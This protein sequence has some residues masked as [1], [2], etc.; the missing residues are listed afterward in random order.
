LRGHAGAC[1]GAKQPLTKEDW[2]DIANGREHPSIGEMIAADARRICICGH[3]YPTHAAGGQC[4]ACSECD[5]FVD[6]AD[7]REAIGE[8]QGA[9]ARY[10]K[11]YDATVLQCEA[12]RAS[13]DELAASLRRVTEERNQ[14]RADVEGIELA[15]RSELARSDV[16]EADGARWKTLAEYGDHLRRCA[17]YDVSEDHEHLCDCGFLAAYQGAPSGCHFTHSATPP[18]P[19]PSEREEDR[20]GADEAKSCSHTNTIETMP[21]V[22]RDCGKTLSSIG[23]PPLRGSA[24]PADASGAS[25][26]ERDDDLARIARHNGAPDEFAHEIAS[27]VASAVR[28]ECDRAEVPNDE[29][30][31]ATRAKLD[32]AER[33]RDDLRATIAAEIECIV[34]GRIPSHALPLVAKHVRLASGRD[35][36]E[37]TVA[38]LDAAEREAASLAASA[39]SLERDR[40]YNAGLVVERDAEVARLRAERDEARADAKRWHDDSRNADATSNTWMAK[41][42]EAEKNARYATSELNKA[43]RERD[44][45]RT[46]LAEARAAL[47]S[48]SDIADDY[49]KAREAMKV[50][51][52]DAHTRLEASKEAHTY[53]HK[54]WEEEHAS[55]VLAE[56]ERAEVK[57]ESARQ[58][59]ELRDTA[60]D[61]LAAQSDAEAADKRCQFAHDERDAERRDNRRLRRK[62]NALRAKVIAMREALKTCALSG[63]ER[64]PRRDTSARWTACVESGNCVTEWCPGCVARAA[65]TSCADAGKKGAK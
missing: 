7:V 38:R 19:M 12:L 35:L 48:Q 58:F 27:A 51:L 24:A 26:E 1:G 43:E 11:R 52:A 29:A 15:Y 37:T 9:A 30:F 31:Y 53:W 61:L 54:Q 21:P 59:A 55:R 20:G 60:R 18:R 39:A 36:W 47:A 23:L 16:A 65:L 46:E 33:E 13:N 25:D 32:A 41:L 10:R 56:R 3:A 62:S 40:E 45:L 44:R 42:D 57:A 22:C 49:F 17:A 28:A 2:N 5:G 34:D 4:S 6:R 63:C 8:A 14:L 64:A 50:E